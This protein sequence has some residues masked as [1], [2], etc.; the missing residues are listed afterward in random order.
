M[1]HHGSPWI[2]MDHHG[3]PWWQQLHRGLAPFP[4]GL[5]LAAA[6]ELAKSGEWPEVSMVIG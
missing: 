3:S 2:T 6:R 5:G 1:D 4:V